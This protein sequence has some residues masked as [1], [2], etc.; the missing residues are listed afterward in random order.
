MS[1]LWDSHRPEASH[2]SFWRAIRDERVTLTALFEYPTILY[3]K[4]SKI[5]AP[6]KAALNLGLDDLVL[7]VARNDVGWKSW[8]EFGSSTGVVA[9]HNMSAKQS[10][11]MKKVALHD[12]IQN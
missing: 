12:G 7:F 10:K 8:S 1:I 3:S 2:T 9:T 5:Q 11:W 6:I 4:L